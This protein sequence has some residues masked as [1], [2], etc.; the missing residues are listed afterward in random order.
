MV[1]SHIILGNTRLCCTTQLFC[2]K[3][4]LSNNAK[5]HFSSTV[6]DY[7]TAAESVV[8]KNDE[9]HSE[10]VN[11]LQ[12][13]KDKPIK[14]LDLGCGT[15]HGLSLVLER[16]PNSKVIGVDFSARMI[17]ACSKLIDR[18]GDRVNLVE[19]DFT[20]LDFDGSF[21][22]VISAMAIHNVYSD[23][24]KATLFEKIYSTLNPG[25]YFVNGDFVK[26]E[27]E[28]AQLHTKKLYKLFVENNLSADKQELDV[29]LRHIEDDDRP[30]KLSE[31]FAILSQIGFSSI[32]LLW[33]FGYEALYSAKKGG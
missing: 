10:L 22:A 25:G 30:M 15:G 20:S 29:W 18:F 17:Q 27:T 28:F 1:I 21:D 31:Q 32:K 14:V 13:E 24:N 11:A 5:K 12:F 6:L 26:G 33:L 8:M 4:K 9:L 19:A 2:E 7:D 3:T 16:F 23:D